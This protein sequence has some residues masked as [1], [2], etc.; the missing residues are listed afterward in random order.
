MPIRTMDGWTEWHQKTFMSNHPEAQAPVHERNV[1]PEAYSG[2][3]MIRFKEFDVEKEYSRQLKAATAAS[4]AA[5]W[6]QLVHAV[7]LGDAAAEPR[8]GT[9][10]VYDRL[11]Q[12]LQRHTA[13][14]AEAR[15]ELKAFEDIIVF[16]SFNVTSDGKGRPKLKKT[17]YEKCTGKARPDGGKKV[18]YPDLPPEK[19]LYPDLPLDMRS[20]PPAPPLAA[21]PAPTRAVFS[22]FTFLFQRPGLFSA[23]TLLI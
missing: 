21:W 17:A 12:R 23:P 9:D 13:T 3:G 5:E 19:V 20:K 2:D 7:A 8:F 4:D 16:G 11:C 14:K 18:L 6:T 15:A 10:P 22:P 1:M